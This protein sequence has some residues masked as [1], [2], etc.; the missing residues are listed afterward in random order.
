MKVQKNI[1]K[2][3][4]YV[5]IIDVQTKKNDFLIKKFVCIKGKS[6]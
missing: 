3:H 1:Q 4:H 2:S 5:K 6:K